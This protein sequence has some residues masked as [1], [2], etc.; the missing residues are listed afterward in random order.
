MPVIFRKSIRDL[1]IR[2]RSTLVA[3]LAL[4][5]GLWG[6]GTLLVSILVMSNDLQENYLRTHPAHIS[7]ISED[8]AK[9]DLAEIRKNPNIEA[10]EFRDKA[11]LRIEVNPGKW[12]PLWLYSVDDFKSLS[13][14][15][16]FRQSGDFPPPRGSLSIERNVQQISDLRIGTSARVQSGGR[17]IR[18]TISGTVFDP[19]QAPATQDA[20]VYA[21]TDKENYTRLSGETTNRR[22]VVRFQNVETRRDVEIQFTELSRELSRLGISINSY[23]I[24][25][26]DQHPHQFQLNTL[27]YLNAIIGLLAFVMAMVLVS[28]LMSSIFTRQIRQIGIMK[29][30]GATR[31]QIFKAYAA[32]IIIMSLPSIIVGLPLAVIT[33]KAYSAFVA[34]I[35]NFDILT[36]QLPYRIYAAIIL[37]G[38]ILP[39]VFS[40]PALLKGMKVSVKD[41][42]DDY[43]IKTDDSP[44]FSRLFN[45]TNSNI[46]SLAIRNVGR[47]KSRMAVTIATM[48]LGVALFLT[49][50]NVRASLKEFL[51]HTS[52][53]MK[54]DIKVVLGNSQQ[55]DIAIAPFSTLEAVKSIEGWIGGIGRIQSENISTSSGIGLVAAPFD[56]RLKDHH[57]LKGRWLSGSAELEFVVNQQAVPMFKPV[58]I[59]KS[60]QLHIGDKRILAKLVGVVREFD[61]AKIYVDFAKYNKIAN[62]DWKINSLMISLKDRSYDNVIKVKEEVERIIEKAGIDVIYVMSQAERAIIIFEHLN[63]IL[64]TILFLSLLV[65]LVS[66]I[67]MGSAMG[68][69]VI[70]R[71]REIGVLR[72]IGAT[73]GAITKLF[74][75]EGFFISAF[76]VALGLL[77]A[78]PMSALS[79]AFFGELILG[80]QTPLDFAFNK[81]G[82]ALTLIVT[83]IFGY[84]ASRIPAGKATQ[85]IVHEAI[86]YE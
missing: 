2:Y 85:I 45:I 52:Q 4:T 15:R 42:L 73:P 24:P 84:L 10:V 7:I 82:F 77:L 86:A 39:L 71:T 59:G 27:L 13:L 26:F 20:F 6:V 60:Y 5:I 62:P 78:L 44:F 66:S 21:Y 32:Y 83:L 70:E 46:L 68:I 67:G 14:S 47:R 8:F 49:G 55:S 50:F 18:T 40:L 69:N 9:L 37:L 22:I 81:S 64:M 25:K 61:I 12:L 57:L 23:K 74:V 34:G 28:Q 43:G 29:A 36:T 48:A 33:G 56:S 35:L 53:S 79:A 17:I 54:Y 75:I 76:S 11:I 31:S 63:I 72:A 58:T 80:E 51:D 65:L 19:G 1:S 38:I 30:I 16:F 41:A 3:I